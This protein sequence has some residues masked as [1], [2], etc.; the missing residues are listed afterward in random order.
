QGVDRHPAGDTGAG[1]EEGQFLAEV[2]PGDEEDAAVEHG[3]RSQEQDD[4]RHEDVGRQQLSHQLSHQE[5]PSSSPMPVRSPPRRYW[6]ISSMSS[7]G[8]IGPKA[9]IRPDPKPLRP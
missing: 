3:D 6:A 9:G 7:W 4:P 5:L 2:G 8:R 1:D